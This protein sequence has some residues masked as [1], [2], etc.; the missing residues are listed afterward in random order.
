MFYDGELSL[1]ENYKKVEK[2]VELKDDRRLS[3][4]D[5]KEVSVEAIDFLRKTL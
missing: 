4:F 2:F 3:L 5:Y 1:A